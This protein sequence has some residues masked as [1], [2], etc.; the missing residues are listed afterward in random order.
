MAPLLLFA[1]IEIIDYKLSDILLISSLSLYGVSIVDLKQSLT[2]CNKVALVLKKV[3]PIFDNVGFSLIKQTGHILKEEKG[4]FISENP[5]LYTRRGLFY[6]KDVSFLPFWNASFSNGVPQKF[7][8][9]S[10]KN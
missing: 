2:V 6:K 1:A 9:R 10:R 5:F 8:R 3:Q 4:L 7:V